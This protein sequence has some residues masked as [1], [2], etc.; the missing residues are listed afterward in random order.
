[1]F[2]VALR[3]HTGAYRAAYSLQLGEAIWVLHA[4]QKKATQGGKTPK[5]EIELIRSRL[6][7]LKQELEL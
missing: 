1:V 6:R 2:E 5:K 3:H 7:R 4:F